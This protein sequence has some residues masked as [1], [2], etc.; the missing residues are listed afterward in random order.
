MLAPNLLQAELRLSSTVDTALEIYHQL[1]KRTASF[2]M[3]DLSAQGTS[4]G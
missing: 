4:C 2:Q 1:R 3:A